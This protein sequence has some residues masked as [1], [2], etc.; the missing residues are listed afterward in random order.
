MMSL[1]VVSMCGNELEV[2]MST[3]NMCYVK[4]RVKQVES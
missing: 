1:L 3:G 2:G 4:R